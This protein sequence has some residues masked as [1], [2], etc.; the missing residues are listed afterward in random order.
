[1]DTFFKDREQTETFAEI[2][3][4][5]GSIHLDFS[6]NTGENGTDEKIASYSLTPE[7]LLSILEDVKYYDKFEKQKNI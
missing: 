5:N 4:D 3:V 7:R 1:M 2:E 6:S